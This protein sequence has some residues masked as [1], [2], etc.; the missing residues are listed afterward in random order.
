MGLS[1][2]QDKE[3]AELR[4]QL[5][6]ALKSLEEQHAQLQTQREVV[7][8][9]SE[10]IDEL[11]NTIVSKEIEIRQL[12]MVRRNKLILLNEFKHL[13]AKQQ[14]SINVPPPRTC[15]PKCENP[16]DVKGNAIDWIKQ[17]DQRRVQNCDIN[18]RVCFAMLVGGYD[19][20][21][22][23]KGTHL[24]ESAATSIENAIKVKALLFSSDNAILLIRFVDKNET[25]G[26]SLVVYKLGT[27]YT[28]FQAYYGVSDLLVFDCDVTTSVFGK[29]Y[30][31]N[32]SMNSTSFGF[33]KSSNPWDIHSKCFI[34]Y[35]L[36]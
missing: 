35:K 19:S 1:Q 7:L 27:T 23:E 6:G 17:V 30:S 36:L 32:I 2:S 18:A 25:D 21:W 28:T 34:V 31:G 8:K 12:Q 20:L 4:E 24:D 26:H 9:L 5:E 10:R 15:I 22:V 3:N 11:N 13:Y 16:S 14:M 29:I 33:T